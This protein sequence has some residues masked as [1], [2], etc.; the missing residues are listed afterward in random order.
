MFPIT[1]DLQT[2]DASQVMTDLFHIPTDMLQT[3]TNQVHTQPQTCLKQ[4][5]TLFHIDKDVSFSKRHLSQTETDAS[6]SSRGDIL[7]KRAVKY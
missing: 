6:H 7:P 5:L 1:T 4:P 2:M 3:T